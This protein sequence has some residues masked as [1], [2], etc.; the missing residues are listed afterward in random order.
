MTMKTRDFKAL[1]E[2]RRNF[3]RN[4]RRYTYTQTFNRL[5]GRTGAEFALSRRIRQARA[6]LLILAASL[7]GLGFLFMIF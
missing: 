2:R 4:L 1:A 7:F 3:R 5:A 6:A